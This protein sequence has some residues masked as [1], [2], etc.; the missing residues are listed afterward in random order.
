TI[1]GF[2][3][4]IC[5]ALVVLGALATFATRR[6]I[7]LVA[8]LLGLA[9]CVL[10]IAAQFVEGTAPTGDAQW[11]IWL[12][13]IGIVVCVLWIALSKRENLEKAG[14]HALQHMQ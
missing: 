10:G 9:T 4:C 13:L 5:Y 7:D 14:K 3:A 2:L 11:G 1:A 6:P 12:S 8:A